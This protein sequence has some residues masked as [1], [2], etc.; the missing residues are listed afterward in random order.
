[1]DVDKLLFQVNTN[2]NIL[3]F[4][5]TQDET[6]KLFILNLKNKIRKS[7]KLVIFSSYSKLKLHFDEIFDFLTC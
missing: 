2:L 5:E 7:F 4:S 6:I 3:K 1:M